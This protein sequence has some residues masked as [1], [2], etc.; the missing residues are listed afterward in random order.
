M[1]SIVIGNSINSIT[2]TKPEK[3]ANAFN[4]YFVS[5][6]STIQSTSRFSRKKFREFLH[7][8]GINSFYIKS[9]D[10]IDIE[11]II[12]YYLL[13]AVVPNSIATKIIKL[14]SNNI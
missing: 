3:I 10:K 13:K 2:S 4:K 5:I 8:I 6:S 9:V 14:P 11:N 1:L 12:S 7:D